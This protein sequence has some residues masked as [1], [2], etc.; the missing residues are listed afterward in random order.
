MLY[1]I[2]YR[3]ILLWHEWFL[4]TYLALER[5]VSHLFRFSS[6]VT[7]IRNSKVNGVCNNIF[8][9]ILLQ[10]MSKKYNKLYTQLSLQRLVFY[11]NC[12]WEFGY[13]LQTL[14]FN[15]ILHKTEYDW[16]PNPIKINLLSIFEHPV[17]QYS[18]FSSLMQ[19]SGIKLQWSYFSYIFFRL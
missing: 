11:C 19:F 8:M 10:V 3:C 14:F 15:Y 13:V 12:R 18:P 2:C 1:G 16:Q 7:Y 4:Q 6:Y 17:C 9:T 5:R